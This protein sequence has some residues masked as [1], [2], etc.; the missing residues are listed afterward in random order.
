M[1]EG[2][3]KF[4]ITMIVFLT[5]FKVSAQYTD[6][7]FSKNSVRFNIGSKANHI[8]PKLKN[9]KEHSSSRSSIRINERV[10][11]EKSSK[12]TIIKSTHGNRTR[13]TENLQENFNVAIKGKYFP[14]GHP[15]WID[16][17]VYMETPAEVMW[18]KTYPSR[19]GIYRRNFSIGGKKLSELDRRVMKLRAEKYYRAKFPGKSLPSN[20]LLIVGPHPKTSG[21][22]NRKTIDKTSE[23]KD[24]VRSL[25]E[26]KLLQNNSDSKAMGPR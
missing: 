2:M 5:S 18:L 11:I 22:V 17:K 10:N 23:M 7:D 24:L 6:V 26:K 20:Y 25:R 4:P 3:L 12:R 9:Y 16:P 8:D 1:I 21:I 15:E 13:V 19:M 14:P